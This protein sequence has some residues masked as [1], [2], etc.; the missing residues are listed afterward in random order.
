MM[1]AIDGRLSVTDAFRLA[2]RAQPAELRVQSAL[3]RDGTAAAIVRAALAQADGDVAFAVRVLEAAFARAPEDERPF[4]ADL[5]VPL[6]I[7]TGSLDRVEKY[8]CESLVPMLAAGA[9]A[10]WAVVAACRG[11]AEQSRAHALFAE[12]ASDAV[13]DLTMR[14]R[15][16][17]RLALAAFY[18]AEF[19]LADRLVK[20]SAALADRA[21]APRYAAT[22]FSLG[23][24]IAH[25]VTGDLDA[26]ARYAEALVTAGEACGDG[27][28][29]ASGLVCTYELAA[30]RADDAEALR[31]QR[32]L[33]AKPLPPQYRERF[34]SVVADALPMAWRGDFSGFR[35]VVAVLRDTPERSV[36]ERAVCDAFF[37]LAAIALEHVDDARRLSRRALA[38]A[39]PQLGLSAFESR[40]RRLARALGA[41]ACTIIGDTVR[42]RRGADV[43]F[44]REDPDIASLVAL[45][46]GGR[47]ENAAL[48]VRGYAR[49]VVATRDALLHDARRG[50]LTG[51]ELG[52]LRQLAVG[53]SAPAIAR[54][55]GRSVHTIRTQTSAIVNKL[56]ARGRGEAVARARKLGLLEA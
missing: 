9:E 22:A 15:I 45:A 1:G 29:R 47:W 52:V 42:G 12:A 2:L 23:Y 16:Q 27:S 11:E 37:A 6:L 24:A 43:R 4:V 39:R 44:L 28:I 51:A 20:D 56:G 38:A 17:G 26:A 34:A 3:T 41:A 31:I 50:V 49:L 48:R 7:S 54:E 19:A 10:L 14:A 25:D 40:Y 21:G 18:R 46:G 30:E 13:D 33:R 53:K 55:S 32:I 5:V 36:G 35:A 8:A